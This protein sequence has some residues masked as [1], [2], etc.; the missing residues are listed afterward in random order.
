MR[1]PVRPS[2]TDGF[3]LVE[4]LVVI[5]IIGILAAIALPAFLH[6]RAKAQDTEAKT[7]VVTA[8]KALEAWRTDHDGF[9]AVT[10]A[11][12]TL[13]EP[14][15]GSARGLSPTNTTADTYEV[16]V[17]SASGT[18]GGGPFRVRRYADGHWDRLCDSPGQGSCPAGGTW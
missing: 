3:T 13:V 2:T 7:A 9:Q 8:A 6:Q 4:L 5:L 12:L 18:S 15:L 1:R 16:S 10:T 17:N 14:T 11:D